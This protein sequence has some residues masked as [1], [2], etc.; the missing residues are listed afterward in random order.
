MPQQEATSQE[1]TIGGGGSNGGG[2]TFLTGTT[3]TS[4]GTYTAEN[5]YLRNVIVLAAG[6]AFPP[7][8]DGKKVYWT[9]LSSTGSSGKTTDGG[10]TSVKVEAGAA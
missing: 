1:L 9:A 3:C 6:D 8:V 7:F 2:G 4:S 10:F 5:K